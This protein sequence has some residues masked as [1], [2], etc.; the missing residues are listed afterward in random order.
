[1]YKVHRDYYVVLINNLAKAF[2]EYNFW[3]KLHPSEVENIINNVAPYNYNEHLHGENIHIIKDSIPVGALLDKMDCLIHYGSTV[4]L[5][6]YIY[7]V[8]SVYLYCKEM[9]KQYEE[10]SFTNIEVTDYNACFD[11]LNSDM[12]F[13]DNVVMQNFLQDV[14]NYTVDESYTPSKDIAEFL[15]ESMQHQNL[16]IDYSNQSLRDIL[17][18]C[19]LYRI[20]ILKVLLKNILQMNWKENKRSF[21]LF[22]KMYRNPWRCIKDLVTAIVNHIKE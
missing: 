22:I 19:Y 2:P 16:K 18:S 1:M 12:V 17:D 13:T 8:P 6:A 10:I 15:N 11:Y 7:K 3:V 20:I 5:E 21:D 9:E 4:C 14:M